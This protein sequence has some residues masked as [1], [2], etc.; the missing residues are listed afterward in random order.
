M[1]RALVA[2]F[3]SV[4]C[5]AAVACTDH[6]G[7]DA[8]TDIAWI[9][10]DVS[11]GLPAGDAGYAPI[12]TGDPLPIRVGFQGFTFARVV[13]AARGDVP[14]IASGRTV[15]TIDGVE[16]IRQNLTNI[17]FTTRPDGVFYSSPVMVFANDI[18]GA[19][20]HG[21]N[22]R[23]DVTFTDGNRRAAGTIAGT[24]FYDSLCID[25]G[26]GGCLPPDGGADA[27]SDAACPVDATTD[28]TGCGE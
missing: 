20:V 21:R 10:Y 15:L 9:D 22:Y 14:A 19:A 3:V 2:I 1:N 18:V 5:C 16:P 23:L 17:D 7:R 26:Y 27:G 6:P 13:F 12:Q 11:V 4:A 8:S 28:G 25:D 24:V